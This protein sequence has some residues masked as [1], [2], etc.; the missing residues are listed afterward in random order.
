MKTIKKINKLLKRII[1][2]CEKEYLLQTLT[3]EKW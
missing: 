1:S 3:K 2:V